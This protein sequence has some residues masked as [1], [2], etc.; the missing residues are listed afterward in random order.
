M[1]I[2]TILDAA[3][4]VRSRRSELDLSQEALAKRA[5]VSRKWVYEF[6]AGKPN[7][8]L[9]VLLRVLTALQLT[10]RAEAALSSEDADGVDLDRLLDEYRR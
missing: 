1:L 4:V 7:A 3:S 6:E 8:E 10:L 2:H 9:G 5:G